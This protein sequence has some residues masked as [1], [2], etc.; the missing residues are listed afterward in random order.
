MK[1]VLAQCMY[2]AEPSYPM[3]LFSKISQNGIVSIV[4]YG[5]S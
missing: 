3:L 2:L 4:G 5:Q 1:M